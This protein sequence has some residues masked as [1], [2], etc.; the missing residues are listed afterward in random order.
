MWRI[1][2]NSVFNHFYL[3]KIKK[4]VGKGTKTQVGSQI[5]DEW[6]V[7]LNKGGLYNGEKPP[8]EGD[9]KILRKNIEEDSL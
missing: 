6:T 9:R 1:P 7:G 8:E 4:T 3:Q 2:L 5:V